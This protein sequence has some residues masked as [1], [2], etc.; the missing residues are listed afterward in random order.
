VLQVVIAVL[1]VACLAVGD[2]AGAPLQ[3]CARLVSFY[4]LLAFLAR[5]FQIWNSLSDYIVN[6][7]YLT[8]RI[9]ITRVSVS[10]SQLKGTSNPSLIGSGKGGNVTSAGWQVVLCDSVSHMAR[11]FP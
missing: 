10:D 3:T 9:L 11:K 6:L 5:N 1:S 8:F 4:V 2:V 7:I